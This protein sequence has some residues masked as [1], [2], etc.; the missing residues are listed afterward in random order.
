MSSSGKSAAVAVTEHGSGTRLQG[1]GDSQSQGPPHLSRPVV[2]KSASS[3][4]GSVPA[5]GGSQLRW[6]AP[7]RWRKSLRKH[8]PE[9][10]G[11]VLP[12]SSDWRA[13]GVLW[14]LRRAWRGRRCNLRQ[15][16]P[17][18]DAALPREIRLGPQDCNQCAA[19]PMSAATDRTP[20]A[21]NPNAVSHGLGASILCPAYAPAP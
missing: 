14:R 6:T 1:G 18:E 13:S 15:R 16:K 4:L 8:R 2:P 19:P 17:A 11:A 5:R 10:C 9:S 7:E 3:C 21:L 20:L 12:A